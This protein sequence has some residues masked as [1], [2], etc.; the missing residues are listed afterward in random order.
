MKLQTRINLRVELW[1]GQRR[2]SGSHRKRKSGVGRDD[3][4]D[5][6]CIYTV[7]DWI[8][9]KPSRNGC[10]LVCVC[11][12]ERERATRGRKSGNKNKQ[13]TKYKF[14]S[15]G[16]RCYLPPAQLFLS[17]LDYPTCPWPS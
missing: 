7:G 17:V 1:Q 9:A 5:E 4:M 11:D 8:G 10:V 6:D 3:T 13:E 15:A 16:L 12:R 2:Q 14:K